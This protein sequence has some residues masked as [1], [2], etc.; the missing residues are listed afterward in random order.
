MDTYVGKI[1][2]GNSSSNISPIASTMFGKC[3]TPASDRTKIV[4]FNKFDKLMHGVTIFVCFVQG[5][6]L[7]ANI[8]LQ[9]NNTLP[10]DI[11]GNCIC[12]E[13]EI[14]AFTFDEVDATHKY[15]RVT[16]TGISSAMEDFIIRTINNTT[17]TP[18]VLIF[19]GTIGISGDPG[20]LPNSGYDIGWTYQVVTEGEYLGQHCE[21]GALIIATHK[22]AANQ[23]LINT[24]HWAVVTT[25]TYY[26]GD[27]LNLDLSTN[28]FSVIYGT[29]SGT[30]AEGNDPRLS[31]ARIP[32]EHTHGRISNDG[33]IG[34][35]NA[36]VRTADGEIT[37]GP[38]ISSSS[39]DAGKFLNN[40]G[41]WNIPPYPVTSVNGSTGD[42]VITL[43]DLDIRTVRFIGRA[44]VVIE[45]RSTTNPVISEYN[46]PTDRNNGDIVLGKT[47]GREYIWTEDGWIMLGFSASQIMDSNN[48]PNQEINI[49]N[50]P[51]WI[52]RIT[53]DTDGTV[54]VERST[55]GILPIGHGGTGTDNFL[56]DQVILSNAQGTSLTSRN[57]T[58]N[59]ANTALLST[60]T[61]FITE[62]SIY[63]G[64][65]F[66]NNVH[67]Y[68]SNDYIFAPIT[69]GTQYQLLVSSG[70]GAPVWAEAAKVE[71]EV[72]GVAS[73]NAFT[74]LKLGNNVAKTS[75]SAHSEGKILLYSSG[76]DGHEI[77]GESTNT[78]YVHTLP[79][80]T[81][82]FVQI[83]D[84]TATVGNNSQPVYIAANGMATALE[85]TPNRLYYSSSSTSFVPTD[86]Y[87]NATQIGINTTE[88]PTGMLDNF[89]VEGNST[90]SNNV[91]I[92]G[93]TTI[94]KDT[95]ASING[96]GALVVTGGIYT[97]ES[98]F[99]NKNLHITEKTTLIDRVSIGEELGANE[100][101]ILTIHGNTKIKGDNNIVAYLTVDT[102]SN[103][104]YLYF[105]P[106]LSGNGIIGDSDHA[107]KSA[108]FTDEVTVIDGNSNGITIDSSG[109]INIVHGNSTI[110]LTTIDS[111]N[112][113]GIISINAAKPTIELN[114]TANG[115]TN[116]KITN[117][118][119][120]NVFS[121]N[122]QGSPLI[123]LK[124][125]DHGFELTN[126]LYINP[127]SDLSNGSN[128]D[129][130]VNGDSEL[131]G[132]VG[133]GTE[134]DLSNN[135]TN[136]LRINGNT[137]IVHDDTTSVTIA[138][139]I[140]RI[141]ATLADNSLRDTVRFYPDQDQ[142]GYIG[143]DDHRWKEGYFS[144]ILAI[145][146]YEN[147]D[148]TNGILLDKEGIVTIRSS[149]TDSSTHMTTVNT[150]EL[151]TAT[152]GQITISSD[153][154]TILLDTLD[155][156]VSDWIIT[157]DAL[158]IFSINNQ[159]S[160]LIEL[161]GTDNGF[162][163]TNRLYINPDAQTTDLDDQS[164]LDLYVN[165]T[166]ELYG[167]TGI[168]VT[169]H[170][171]Y[172]LNI[173]GNASAT[174]LVRFATS[175]D[176]EAAFIDLAL[177]NSKNTIN[178]YPQETNTG[179]LGLPN[180]GGN[181]DNGQRWKK[182]YIGEED[183]HG[184]EY[185]PVYWD[186]G[187][188][189]YTPVVQKYEFEFSN[190]SHEVTITPTNRYREYAIVNSIT[191]TEG[192][193]YLNDIIEWEVTSN[194]TI[195]LYM[196]SL[197]NTSGAVAGYILVSTGTEIISNT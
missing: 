189:T 116:W 70:S 157:N 57:Y 114:T 98:I 158:G 14:L 40:L 89:Y 83:P 106:N 173:G 38:T 42:V 140:D 68:T 41:E 79:N 164:D 135:N 105:R 99:A 10:Y 86:H 50:E 122:N 72:S 118:D 113:V 75:S 90:F 147:D 22:A 63:Y 155:N 74:I 12:G 112:E 179:F 84:S 183:T 6:T 23:S 47:D 144:N 3:S 165:G 124:G 180:T 48:I 5:N 49:V 15:W 85:Y 175:N 187:A 91:N 24:S 123:E 21:P 43:A 97:A 107:W 60:S 167:N 33:T 19:K 92:G 18:D 56:G 11:T 137:E 46:W 115:G 150:I 148:I 129:L 193:S 4:T 146:M 37:T 162:A 120:A 130:Y 66:I 52:S 62:R 117:H 136:V 13:N 58:D 145:G 184:D 141:T 27:G 197:I 133:I 177:E 34:N 178:F 53:Q 134:P 17:E 171:N 154:P 69:D 139:H 190:N 73:T 8:K 100:T 181:V 185:T 95:V 87:A 35:G 25:R 51:T 125:T 67:N 109:F 71:S 103:S 102:I 64:L 174:Q 159:N 176:S 93:I 36:L 1:Q 131:F 191:V 168:G 108:A 16:S 77:N 104:D 9:V 163:L 39:S 2:L 7:S 55:I 152:T 28:E 153:T 126:R 142:T 151:E 127:V 161:K 30:A 32:L 195:H 29:T 81:G 45:E 186:N 101:E 59:D 172:K 192:I 88:L 26:N 156:S 96:T 65:P 143:L 132:H 128:L 138:A 31:D 166:S 121:L 188:P 78:N 149:N 94:S 111:Q 80:V 169:P 82:L 196:Q 110:N 170:A 160:K 61:N 194:N 76:T 44:T 119:L 20:I 182:L 54:Q